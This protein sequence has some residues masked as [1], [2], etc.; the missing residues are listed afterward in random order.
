MWIYPKFWLYAHVFGWSLYCVYTLIPTE[1]R[2]RTKSEIKVGPT[3]VIFPMWEK[4]CHNPPMTGNGLYHLF[5]GIG[6]MVY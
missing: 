1:C 2:I 6:G 3:K 5:M 4:Q